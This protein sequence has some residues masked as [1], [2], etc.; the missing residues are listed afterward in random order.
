MCRT[1]AVTATL[2]GGS[3]VPLALH[4]WP[5]LDL[6]EAAAALGQGRH[7]CHAAALLLSDTAGTPGQPLVS[8][9]A[10][11]AMLE[12]EALG[13]CVVLPARND[14]VAPA[15]PAEHLCWHVPRDLPN[16]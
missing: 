9:E 8:S 11:P 3:T 2:H 10:C 5:L 1:A 15:Q 14:L 7:C 4:C 6:Q 13:L 12:V 16:Q